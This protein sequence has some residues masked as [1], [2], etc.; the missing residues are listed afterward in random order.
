MAQTVDIPNYG[1]PHPSS[2]RTGLMHDPRK[3]LDNK[4]LFAPFF[5]A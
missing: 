3:H 2:E 4:G 1:Y 5:E